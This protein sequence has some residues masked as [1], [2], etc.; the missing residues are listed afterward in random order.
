M[1]Q[2]IKIPCPWPLDSAPHYFFTLTKDFISWEEMKSWYCKMII[3]VSCFSKFSI[4][5][6]LQ[7]F[8]YASGSKD[9]G[10]WMSLVLNLP[11]FWIYQVS[12]YTS[13]FDW[14]I[15]DYVW[16]CLIMLEFVW[17][18]LYMLGYAWICLN[19]HEWLFSYFSL[20][21]HYITRGY[22]FE[23]LQENRGYSLN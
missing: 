17:V 15:P 4:V 1:R 6:V 5:D 22:L 9:P 7:G 10:F 23:G 16:K 21:L 13:G 8:E 18:C 3:A 14:V 2:Y 19:L 11:E 20:W 12:E